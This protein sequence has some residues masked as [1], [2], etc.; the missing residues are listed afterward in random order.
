[1]A[2]ILVQ[3]LQRLHGEI[4][5]QGSKNAALPMMAAA[6]LHKGMTVLTNVPRIQ[7]VFCMMGILKSIGCGCSLD[8]HEMTIDASKIDSV[9]IPERFLT[10]M[11]SS[12]ILMGALLGRCGEAEA[13]YPGGC[14]IGKRPIDLH[15]YALEQLGVTITEQN[16]RLIARAEQLR[17]GE[18]V[19]SFPSVGATENA[20]LTAVMAEGT[21]VIRGAAMEPEICALCQMLNDMG[22]EMEGIGSNVLKIRGVSELHDTIWAVPGDR[23]VAGTYLYGLLAAGGRAVFRGVEPEHLKPVLDTALQMGGKV[24]AEGACI[25]AVMEQRPGGLRVQTA[26]YPGF[27]T[28][29]QS[30]LLAVMASGTGEGSIRETVFEGRFATALQLEKMGARIFV[31]GDIARVYGTYPLRGCRVAASDLRGGAALVIAGM[32]ADG[33]TRISGCRHI[34]RGYESICEDLRALGAT[35]QKEQESMQENYDWTFI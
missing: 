10:A 11:R 26:P 28:D 31:E 34:F 13:G 6:V 4:K 3:G 7:D 9:Q 30:P 14:T 23:I 8:G 19:F 24:C 25:E 32:A 35:I 16:E 5:I 15:L 21:T 33:E 22:A 18:I 20:I 17:A 29:L 1:M 27:P 12:I 2:E